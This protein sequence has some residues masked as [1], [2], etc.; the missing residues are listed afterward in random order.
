MNWRAKSLIQNFCAALPVGSDAVYYGLQRHFGSLRNP[1]PPGPLL[2]EAADFA[3]WLRGAGVSIQGLRC[4][5]VG[6]GRRVDLPFGLYLLGASH[7]HTFDLNPYLR[8]EIVES[9]LK[10]MR[11][12]RAEVEAMLMPEADD[13]DDFRH[14]LDALL[15]ARTAADAVQQ[16]QVHYHAPADAAQSGL[17]AGSIDLHYSYTVNEH[18][19]AEVLDA[20]LREACRVLS[21]DG[22][23]LHHVDPSDHFSHEDKSISAIH[24]LQFTPEEWAA[25][26][27][28]R[29]AYHNRLRAHE[30]AEIF[31]RSGLQIIREKTSVDPRCMEELRNNFPLAAE[32]RKLTPEQVCGTVI[33]L[34]GRPNRT[35]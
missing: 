4:F 10:W 34:M 35:T 5:E 20:I 30:H 7:T 3:R 19:P 12:N 9:S 11:E 21:P 27:S 25:H 26:G 6:T 15:S 23:A 29:F 32:F 28:N 1:P 14:R 24:F 22:I 16:A 18:I 17:P 2:S 8:M 13:K 33:R 31:R